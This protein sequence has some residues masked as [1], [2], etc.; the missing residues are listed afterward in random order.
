MKRTLFFV[1]VALFVL[2]VPFTAMAA[3][4]VTKGDGGKGGTANT[5][6]DPPPP[7]D[8]PPVVIPPVDT[9]PDHPQCTGGNYSHA[10]NWWGF[11]TAFEH[12]RAF[13]AIVSRLDRD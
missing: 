4:T 5:P 11:V 9:T 7:V 13:R 1:L 2:A 10:R 6:G 8:T 3:D 12:S